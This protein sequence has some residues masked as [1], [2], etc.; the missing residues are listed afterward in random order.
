LKDKS[1]RKENK[2]VNF[3]PMLAWQPTVGGWVGDSGIPK[4]PP[5]YMPVPNKKDFCV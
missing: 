1:I 3:W 2:K 4:I 5:G